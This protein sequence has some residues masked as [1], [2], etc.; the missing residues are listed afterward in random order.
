[1]R[2][3]V[4][5]AW[6]ISIVASVFS[7]L[8]TAKALPLNTRPVKQR[9]LRFNLRQFLPTDDIITSIPEDYVYSPPE[10]GSDIYIG[11][12]VSLI[13]IVW[14]TYE[15]GSRLVIQ[16]QCLV[17][18]GSGLTTLTRAG[19]TLDRL[20]KCWCCGGFL[21]WV[22]WKEFFFANKEV[23]NGGPLQRPA[24]DFKSINQQMREKLQS[25]NL[26]DESPR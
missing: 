6:L 3:S 13:P 18:N 1:M 26:D 24:K 9:R 7:G 12:F 23:G 8:F 21:P 22:G 19:T 10:V 2:T 4:Y 16:R 25:D 5:L 11:S 20:R 17:C 15:F 14:A